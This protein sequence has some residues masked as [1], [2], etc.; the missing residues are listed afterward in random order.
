MKKERSPIR[1]VHSELDI[2]TWIRRE[3]SV[4]EVRPCWCPCCGAASRVP[5][6]SL[7]LHGHGV[8]ERQVRGP[9]ERRGRPTTVIVAARRYRC[10]RCRA[11]I[12]VVPRGILPRRLFASTAI[13][14]ALWLFG[15][16]RKSPMRV[17]CGGGNEAMHATVG[18][19]AAARKFFPQPGGVQAC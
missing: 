5:G 9:V 10:Q 6:A 13:A 4:D 11:V 1:L 18:S 19:C 15:V 16:E 2:K 3:P 14:W 17:R 7:A 12:V 8:R